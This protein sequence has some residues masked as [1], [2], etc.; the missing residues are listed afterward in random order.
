MKPIAPLRSKAWLPYFLPFSF[1]YLS[2]FA[3][4][5]FTLFKGKKPTALQN[6]SR[7]RSHDGVMPE[8][9]SAAT[10]AS[11]NDRDSGRI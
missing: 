2:P 5:L 1:A 6:N 7:D 8:S 11:N 4:F 9:A 10:M 3:D